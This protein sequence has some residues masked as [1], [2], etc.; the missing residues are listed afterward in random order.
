MILATAA[1]KGLERLENSDLSDLRSR[2]EIF[3]KSLKFS[4]SHFDISTDKHSPLAVIRS[5]AESYSSR[6]EDLSRLHKSLL[7]KGFGLS[8]I[9]GNRIEKKSKYFPFIRLAIRC[10]QSNSDISSLAHELSSV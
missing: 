9:T 2:I 4:S 8:L 5:K 6:H 3:K 1:M 7:E 10:N